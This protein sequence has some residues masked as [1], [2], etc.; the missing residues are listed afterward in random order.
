M[1]PHNCLFTPVLLGGVTNSGTPA[2]GGVPS[3]ARPTAAARDPEDLIHAQS[4]AQRHQNGQQRVIFPPPYPL[5]MRETDLTTADRLVVFH[6]DG[7]HA[8][9]KS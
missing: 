2:A 4:I 8:V 1:R 3:Q 6:V 9:D 5:P 7:L